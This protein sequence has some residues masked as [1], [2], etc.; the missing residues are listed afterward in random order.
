MG[1]TCASCDDCKNILCLM[2]TFLK[3]LS[4]SIHSCQQS[5]SRQCNETAERSKGRPCGFRIW[6]WSNCEY[7]QYIISGIALFAVV[8]SYYFCHIYL[9][10][11]VLE[12]HQQGFS[13]TVGYELNPWLVGLARFHAWRAGHHEKVSYRREDLWKVKHLTLVLLP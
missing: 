4:G 9:I 5:S 3:Y 6:W 11:K 8:N 1:G 10:L 7:N 2:R 13:P 12:A